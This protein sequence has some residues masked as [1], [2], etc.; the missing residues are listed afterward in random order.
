MSD[1]NNMFTKGQLL[2]SGRYRYQEDLIQ[3][4][5]DEESLYCVEEVDLM[6]SE[7]LKGKVN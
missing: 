7:F 6:I 4:L 1:N 5:L 3:M 2:L